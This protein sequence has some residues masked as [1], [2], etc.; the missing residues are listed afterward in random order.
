MKDIEATGIIKSFIFKHESG[1]S[2]AKFA[3]VGQKEDFEIKG[4]IGS[5]NEGDFI[6]ITYME[7]MNPT[8]GLQKIVKDA[9]ITD[10]YGDDSIKDYIIF[11]FSGVGEVSANKIVNHFKESTLSILDKDPEKIKEVSGLRAN[12]KNVIAKNWKIVRERDGISRDLIMTL[13]ESGLNMKKINRVMTMISCSVGL[14]KVVE[15]P[16]RI[17]NIEMLSFPIVDSFAL[18]L[19]IEFDNP[20][21]MFNAINYYSKDLIE[22]GD[23][24]I[25]TNELKQ[26]IKDKVHRDENL[27]NKSI[28]DNVEKGNIIIVNKEDT[29]FVMPKEYYDAENNIA[30]A[31]VKMSSSKSFLYDKKFANDW[32]VD[33]KSLNKEQKEAVELSLKN[34]ACI[35]T[36]GPGTGKTT[37]LKSLIKNATKHINREDIAL[38][39]PTGKAAKRM[40]QATNMEARTIHRA[41]A[42]A[43][44]ESFP[45]KVIIIDEASMIDILLMNELLSSMHD[46]QILVILGDA[47]QLPSIGPGQL[48]KDAISSGVVNTVKLV[49]VYRFSEGLLRKNAY[50]IN[51]GEL[52]ETP[53]KG[54]KDSDFY[55]MKYNSSGSRNGDQYA[56]KVIDLIVKIYS[57]SIPSSKG[58]DAFGDIQLLSPMRKNKLGVDNINKI[59]Q[60]AINP[61]KDKKD[62]IYYNGFENNLR[63]NDKVMQKENNYNKSVFNGDTGIVVK[64][65]DKSKRVFVKYE[66]VGVVEYD[67]EDINQLDLAYATTVHKSQG[68]EYDYLIIILDKSHFNMLSRDIVYTAIT[69]AKKMVVMI[70][71]DGAI[72][73]AVR[74]NKSKKR[75]TDLVRKMK[76]AKDKLEK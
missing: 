65:N 5:F 34:K 57:D 68:S 60:N 13:R 66:D 15:N 16:Y 69:R 39:A 45:E 44:G 58:I 53:D 52:P 63:V 20:D 29:S 26:K 6:S 21:R 72:D 35:I 28:D 24:Y 37:I 10:L 1:F 32:K 41:I 43:D 4:D 56:N 33:G 51:R 7:K 47:D 73:I 59:L 61:I 49:E 18:K 64:V 8:Y 31:F 3:A 23:C 30:E 36:G 75:K 48:L 71:E 55:I 12:Q 14:D 62:V 9:Y 38:L 2:I 46:N 50:A 42:M 76:E 70:C 67:L 27:I 17:L 11:K 74:N 19:G 22:Q 25:E 40:K 54:D